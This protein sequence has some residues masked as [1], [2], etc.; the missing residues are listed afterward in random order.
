MKPE[1][2][3]ND[4]QFWNE[5]FRERRNERRQSDTLVIKELGSAGLPVKEITE[6]HFRVWGF[7]D[8]YPTNRKF[9]NTKTGRRGQYQD[10]YRVLERN[11]PK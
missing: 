10:I 5:Y 7:F 6:Y 2:E 1:Q 11:A 8:I 3:Q 4:F 9:H